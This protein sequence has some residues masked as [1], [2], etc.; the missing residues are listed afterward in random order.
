MATPHEDIVACLL[1]ALEPLNGEVRL[2]GRVCDPL[3]NNGSDREAYLFIPDLHLLTPDRQADYDYGFNY[4]ETDPGFK[5]GEL[6]ARL[7]SG[8]C[9]LK[10]DWAARGDRELI[11][12]Q[13]GDFFDL[14]RE[15]PGDMDQ[16][17]IGSSHGAILDLLYRAPYVGGDRCLDAVMLLGNHDTRKGEF[18]RGIQF[19]LNYFNGAAN[20]QPFLFAN[21]GD[22]FDL[23]ERLPEGLKEFAVNYLSGLKGGGDYNVGEWSDAAQQYNQT[24]DFTQAI[25]G[26]EHD[27]SGSNLAVRR[28]PD[29]VLPDH[30]CEELESVDDAPQHFFGK[31]YGAIDEAVEKQ[32]IGQHVRVVVMGHTHMA[33]MLLYRPAGGRPMLLMDVGAWIEKCW[34]PFEENG[35][36]QNVPPE[37]G[38]QLGVIH[39]DDARIYQIHLP[40]TAP[41]GPAANT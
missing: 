24:R 32:L 15:F 2:L 35:A 30:F 21:H 28:M 3:I 18:L 39:G 20:G 11:T 41:A 4:S 14:W 10:S 5:A 7:L 16:S 29:G 9:G 22:A 36:T 23:V 25:A 31:Y 12:I 1:T 38:A 19:S 8:L 33:K 40:A 34:Y 17:Q 26:S 37:P 13:L 27:L 6:L